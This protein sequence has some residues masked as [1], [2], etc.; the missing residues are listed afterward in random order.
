MKG[1]YTKDVGMY[2]RSS[3]RV[4]R[5]ITFSVGCTAVTRKDVVMYSRSLMVI[6]R[7]KTTIEGC[8]AVVDGYLNENCCR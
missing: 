7:Y 6:S 4:S 3:M 2:S 1:M 5:Y 8:S